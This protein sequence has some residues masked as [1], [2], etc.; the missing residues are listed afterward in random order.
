MKYFKTLK[1]DVKLCSEI[2]FHSNWE[3]KLSI[4]SICLLLLFFSQLTSG[5]NKQG[6]VLQPHSQG[7]QPSLDA[8]TSKQ[9]LSQWLAM[10]KA[11]GDARFS[12]QALAYFQRLQAPLKRDPELRLLLAQHLA[13]SHNFEKAI[14]ILTGIPEG[15]P[16]SHQVQLELVNIWMLLGD[17][18]QAS[19]HCRGLQQ[20]QAWLVRRICVLWTEGTTGD[21]AKA[22]ET[23][24]GVLSKLP[25][26]DVLSLWI[27]DI[28][29]DLYIHTEQ[30]QKAIAHLAPL[31]AGPSKDLAAPLQVVDYYLVSQQY[32]EALQLLQ[33]I[34]PEQQF[35]LRHILAQQKRG[36]QL[37]QTQRRRL[38]IQQLN[39]KDSNLFLLSLW[40]QQ[41]M[42]D[43]HRAL[44]LAQD[45]W[46]QFKKHN[47]LLLLARM[48]ALSVGRAISATGTIAEGQP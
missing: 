45:H 29:V 47:D 28:L 24:Q 14:G 44:I 38:Q 7:S 5:A 27:H 32:E 8:N 15:L 34:D 42:A 18:Q 20:G 16:I 46:R 3:L 11:S 37:S 10:A 25:P 21:T 4:V 9:Q 6:L 17:S 33:Q 26:N 35:W 22:I 12:G 19:G 36:P 39:P 40:M 1:Q 41:G 31:L 30:A 2:L 48:Q 13:F 23:L 43:N